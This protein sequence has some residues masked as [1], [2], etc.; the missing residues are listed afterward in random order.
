M[1]QK[2][3]PERN[4]KKEGMPAPNYQT[5][6]SSSLKKFRERTRRLLAV[7]PEELKEQERLWRE[8]NGK[9]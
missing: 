7:T 2:P 8:T 1:P 3:Q 9:D 5:D 6:E 4:D